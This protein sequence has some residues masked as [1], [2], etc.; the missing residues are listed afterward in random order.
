[1]NPTIKPALIGFAFGILPIAACTLLY[2][3]TPYLVEGNPGSLLSFSVFGLYLLSSFAAFVVGVLLLVRKQAVMGGV[4]LAVLFAQA[5]I[6]FWFL[7][8]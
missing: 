6:L 2:Y 5:I 8:L 3:A 1:M 7:G 4:T